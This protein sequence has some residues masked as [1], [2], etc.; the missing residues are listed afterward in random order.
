MCVKDCKYDADADAKTD[1]DDDVDVSDEGGD[2][3]NVFP[4]IC[5]KRIPVLVTMNQK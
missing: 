5:S 2:A 1:D 3:Y 4:I